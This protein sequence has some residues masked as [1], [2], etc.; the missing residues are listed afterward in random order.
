VP[1]HLPAASA[2]AKVEAAA[3]S[4]PLPAKRILLAEDNVVNQ[5]IACLLL[6]KSGHSVLVVSNGKEALEALGQEHF[7]AVLMDLQMPVMDGLDATARLRAR[8]RI[9]GDHVPVIAMTAHA[10]SGDRERCLAAGMDGYVS[11]PV[12]LD[13]L[14]RAI[15]EATSV[16]EPRGSSQST[17]T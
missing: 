17:A 4:A 15:R 10:M 5:R 7:D 16:P 6:Q 1:C 2:P 14:L 11:K 13:A 12:Q 9:S 8:E 3:P